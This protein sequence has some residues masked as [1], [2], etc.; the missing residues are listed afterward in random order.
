M[1][2]FEHQERARRKTTLLV[3]YFFLAVVLIIAAIY[4]VFAY[5]FLPAPPPD[6]AGSAVA[7][8]RNWWRADLLMWVAT[9]IIGIISLGT[10]YKIIALSKGGEAV[11]RMLGARPVP[12]ATTDL[13]ERRLLNVVEEIALASGTPVPRV[14]VLNNENSVNAFAAGFSTQ[15]AII[16]VTNG[17]LT[18]L[19]RDELQGVIAHEFSH[20]LN[21][22]MRLNLRLMGLLNG[23]LIIG[24][25]GF[26]IFRIAA[27]TGRTASVGRKKGGSPIVF[28]LVGLAVM[29]IGYIGVFFG[30][31]IKS[32]VSRQREFLAD[33][34]SVQFTRNP[35][36][37][38]G[39]LKKIGGF[40]AGSRIQN[41]NAEGASHLFFANGLGQSFLNLMATHPPLVERIRRIDPAFSGDFAAVNAASVAV[42]DDARATATGFAQASASR[43]DTAAEASRPS[44]IPLRSHETLRSVGHPQAENLAYITALLNALP[45]TIKIAAREPVGARALV[46]GLLISTDEPIRNAQFQHLT[47]KAEAD[48]AE[49]TRA[50]APELASLPAAAR[51]PLTDMALTALRALS[52]AQVETFQ[53]NLRALIEADASISLFEYMLERMVV[54]RLASQYGQPRRVV[55]QYYD[56]NPLLPAATTLLSTLAYYGQPEEDQAVRAFQSGAARMNSPRRLLPRESCGLAAVDQALTILNTASP[57]IK[58]TILDACVACVAADGR[59]TVTEAELLRSVADALDCPIPPFVPDAA[60]GVL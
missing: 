58:K 46:Y 44:T 38:A 15:D 35:D 12:E 37:L 6:A 52:R 49:R 28:I 2:F 57:A 16:G 40:L 24:I 59:T 21:G 60:R 34:A 32:A 47:L 5:V 7:I 23:I 22:D 41:P 39:A 45:E 13:Q 43:R 3:A 10:F 29:A 14:F 54:R 9:I 56:L 53:A 19:T 48:V 30:K 36:G 42:T 50:L 33:A 17:C 51:M 11:A 4:A 31:L 26:W 8:A 55:V 27:S 1:D 20:I 25:I 18:Q